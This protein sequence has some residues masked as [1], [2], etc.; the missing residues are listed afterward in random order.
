MLRVRIIFHSMSKIGSCTIM[1]ALG[2]RIVFLLSHGAE[3][4][5][6]MKEKFRTRCFLSQIAPLQPPTTHKRLSDV[7]CYTLYVVK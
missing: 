6:G 4:E 7:F 5:F 3:A 1:V 2:T